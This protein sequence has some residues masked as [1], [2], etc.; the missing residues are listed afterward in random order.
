MATQLFQPK[1]LSAGTVNWLNECIKRS[2]SGVFSEVT[3]ITPGLAAELLR[4]N[5]DNRSLRPIKVEQFADDMRDGRWMFNG[6]PIIVAKDG[7]LNDGQHRLHAVID[8]NKPL[9]AI[10][11]FGVERSTRTTVDQGSARTAG[12]YLNMDGVHY[13]NHS[14]SVTRLVLAYEKADGRDVKAAKSF[15]NAQ[16]VGRAKSDKDIVDAAKFACDHSKYARGM[17]SPAVIGAAYYLLNDVDGDDAW[18]YMQ[19][20]CIGENIKRGDPAFAVRDALQ[21]I[22]ELNRQE[23]MEVIFHGWNRYRSRTTMKQ[24]KPSGAGTFPAL[25]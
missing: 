20:V 25:V 13:G 19:Q 14:A 9:N 12:D 24:A 10:V 7:A 21:R 22:G 18:T 8:A 2:R 15:T 17:A 23:M 1:A 3:T 6:E 11:V 4:H 5:K 16:I